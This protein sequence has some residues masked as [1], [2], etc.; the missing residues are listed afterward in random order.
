[1]LL[2]LLYH[3]KIPG[4][5]GGY[6][7]VDVFFVLSGFLITGILFREVQATGDI[8][9][10]A[11]YARRARRLLPAAGF[12][13]LCTLI[14]SVVILP[15]TRLPDATT[16]VVSAGL[17]V[18]NM[19]F[20]LQANDYFQATAA[21]SP[22]LHFWSLSV[23]E[24]FYLFWPAV[25]LFAA[26]G[27]S[28]IGN[29]VSRLTWTLVVL[30]AVSLVAGAW[31]TGVNQPWAF[32]LLPTR[33]WELA[34]GGLIAVLAQRLTR[35]PSTV[36]SLAS[37]VGV[38]CVVAAAL[39]FDD[40]HPLPGHRGRP[41]G[42][43][44]GARD[45]QRA[46]RQP[47]RSRPSPG[48]AADAVPWPHLLLAVP[49]ALADPDLRRDPPR[50]RG[51]ACPRG[52]RDPR[53]SA[54]PAPDRGAAAWRAIH[55]TMPRTNLI[56]AGFLGLILVAVAFGISPPG[57][58]ATIST[59]SGG[60]TPIPA[61]S[62]RPGSS[63]AVPTLSPDIPPEPCSGCAITDL[64][65]ALSD[66]KAGRIEG[67]DD[68]DIPDP[69]KC[70]LGHAS[71]TT[72]AVFGDLHAA[73][74][75]PALEQIAVIEGW[76]LLHLTQGGCPSVAAP[77]WSSTLRREHTE[78]D[79]WREAV[80]ARL[81]L[82]RPKLIILANVSEWPLMS[83]GDHVDPQL[84]PPAA[85]ADVWSKGLATTLDRLAPLGAKIVVV[86]D[87]PN[88]SRAGFDPL[89]CIQENAT[90][91]DTCRAPR[92]PAVA[93]AVHAL[94]RPLRKPTAQRSWIHPTGSAMRPPVPR[95][96][97]GTSSTRTISAT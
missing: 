5:G 97:V 33:G 71:G 34:A 9:F 39:L 82:E 22:V 86:G 89:A 11:F 15:A 44:I 53:R 62:A 68:P 93:S 55:G 85:W 91:F 54:Q 40:A 38:A 29:L 87:V 4:F 50:I 80:F 84:T 41:A 24:Q 70:V 18:S 32:Y 42:R 64:R 77:T 74:L 46:R 49:V 3:A 76:R 6:I 26:H 13:L 61:Q 27:L 72:V 88:P 58:R 14:A 56:Q 69:A 57:E 63:A 2:V 48:P 17:Y 25:L 79:T 52:G 1:M 75:T 73:N 36:G 10:M 51:P 47:D 12:V 81:T 19:R 66:P 60:P 59:S 35:L 37:A 90:T 94:E 16:D 31:L 21:A 30:G 8:S 43:R 45:P 23:E 28:R 65:P 78:C 83:N 7:G 96:S 95:S 92:D 67:C 20:G